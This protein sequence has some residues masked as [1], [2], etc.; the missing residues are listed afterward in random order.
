MAIR[1]YRLPK[2]Y[3]DVPLRRRASGLGMAIALNLLVLLILLGL[4]THVRIVPV[5]KG[6]IKIFSVS[7]D[8]ADDP[9]PKRNASRPRASVPPKTHPPLVKPT[10]TLPAPPPSDRPPQPNQPWVELN[11]SELATVDETLAAPSRGGRHGLDS[12]IVGTGPNGESLY[13][14]EWLREPTNQEL[15]YY[16]PPSRPDGSGMIICKTVPD[17]RVDDCIALESV[18]ASSRLA[19]AVLKAAWQFK[20]RPPRKNGKPMIGTWV[21]IRIDYVT[22][23]KRPADR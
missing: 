4:G 6:G 23:G 19:G 20:I 12:E 14:A 17:N 13:A 1:A 11:P 21:R 5:T 10:I 2:S 8:N 18:P 16:L 15:D 3:D 9:S 7:D 22:V